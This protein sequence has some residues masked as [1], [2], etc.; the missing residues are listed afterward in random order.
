[1]T[2]PLDE[3]LATYPDEI[4]QLA[5]TL[6]DLIHDEIPSMIEQVDT[7]S[8]IIA[9]GYDKTYKGSV[10]A[11]APYQSHLNL[12]FSKGATLP[13]PDGLLEGT[14]KRARHVKIRTADDIT[15]PGVRALLAAAADLTKKDMGIS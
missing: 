3:F 14:G 11:I 5:L 9:Y 7:P 4:R 10:C 6:R 2:N 8:K 15:R 13:D 1:M 12:M